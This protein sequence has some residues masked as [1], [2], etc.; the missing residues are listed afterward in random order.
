MALVDGLFNNVEGF[1]AWAGILLKQSHAA[2]CD[3]ETADSRHVL[4]TK[5]ASLISVIRIDGFRRFVGK[6]EFQQLC[7][8]F[9]ES[10]QGSFSSEGHFIQF[11]FNYSPEGVGYHIDQALHSAEETAARI[12]LNIS[13]IFSSKRKVLSR[14]CSHED[15]FLVLWTEPS[16]LSAKHVKHAFKEQADKISSYNLPLARRAANLFLGLPELRNLHDSLISTVV[17]DLQQIGFYIKLLDVHTALYETRKSIDPGFTAPEWTPSLPGDTVPVRLKEY[18]ND[19]RC[20]ISDILWPPLSSQ[21]I[22]REGENLELKIARIGGMMY[23]P[24]YIELFP[25]SIR[26]F[27]DLFRRAALADLPWRVSFQIA[28]N[29][30][31]VTQSKNWLA[32]FLTFSSYHNKLI[33]ESHKLLKY[34]DERGDDPIIKLKVVLLTWAPVGQ[35]SL[36]KQRSAK[37]AQL[38][39]AWGGCEVK[40]FYGDPYAEVLSSAVAVRNKSAAVTSGAPLSDVVKMLPITRPASPWKKGALLFRTPD[41]KLWPYQPGSNHQVSWIDIIY[42]RSGSG[43]SVLLNSLNLGLCLSPG[44]SQ[45]PR[46]AIIDIGPSSKGFISLLKEGLAADEKNTVLYHRLKLEDGHAINPFD[47]QLGARYPTKLH[48]SFL[49]NLLSLLYVERAQDDIPNGMSGMLSLLV[50]ELYRQFSDHEQAKPYI[51]HMDSYL[52]KKINEINIEIKPGSS[53][54]AVTDLLFEKG[55]S[56]LALRAQKYAMPTLADTIS[57]AHFHGIKDIYAKVSLPNSQEDFVSAFCRTM[58]AVIRNFPTLTTPTQLNLEKARVIAL[59]LEDVARS[60]SAAA[61]KQTAVMYML[62]RH[63]M[64]QHYFLRHDDI[65]AFPKNYQA[66]HEER[67]REI[68]EEPKRIVYDEFHRTANSPSV[69]D[70]VI[71]DMREGRK[72]KIQISLASQALQDF[73]KLMV[74]FAT[75]VFI[76]DSGSTQGIEETCKTFGLNETEKY[77]LATRVHGPKSSGS[78]FIA[79]FV[80]KQGVNTQL[81][82][83]TVSAVELWAF[84]T[85]TEDVYI[86]ESLYKVIGP[87]EARKR[88]ALKYPRGSA[89]KEI[90]ALIEENHDL[91][92][93]GAC[94]LVLK[95]LLH[96]VQEDEE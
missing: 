80:T 63:A 23:Y 37:L 52:E 14:V 65:R 3:L 76:L 83:S 67:I 43:K 11:Y 54:W 64:A 17:E 78:T 27:Y 46:I 19:K 82:T 90:E 86:R 81:L 95:Q 75:G 45:L 21:V 84:N 5:N 87:E 18:E 39:Q 48:R 20:D 61:E 94:D 73:D 74:D 77:A 7:D 10:I 35:M 40:E 92:V 62:S 41:G 70:Q 44:L 15:C 12:N 51:P 26:P 60:G 71:Q 68:L 22:P 30:V 34:L 28:G 4:V 31:K 9:V 79:Q 47:T 24:L 93:A 13:D 1:F 49:I 8:Q 53:W 38:T 89:T 96:D 32:Q 50:D 55:C 29:G 42:A 59:D 91:S 58:S 56:D 33:V 6:A 57:T 36:L 2:Y 88:L 72:W 66:Y 25:K 85:T 69:R 16:A